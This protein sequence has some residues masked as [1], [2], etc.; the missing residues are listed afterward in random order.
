MIY[1]HRIIKA[2]V[3]LAIGVL[4]LLLGYIIGSFSTEI[5]RNVH[6]ILEVVIL[7]S[8][9]IFIWYIVTCGKEN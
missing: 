1:K 3:S 7:G 5:F 6:F 8:L 4:A 2:F 9:I